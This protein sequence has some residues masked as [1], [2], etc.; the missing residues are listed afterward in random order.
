MDKFISEH[1]LHKKID[2]FFE[3]NQVLTGV[4]VASADK[5][6]TIQV[7]GKYIYI[8]IN[9]VKYIMER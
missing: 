5:V 9:Q 3:E 1:L 6:L 4:V 8:N 2:V 7:D